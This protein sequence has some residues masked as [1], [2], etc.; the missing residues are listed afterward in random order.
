ML[1]VWL[2]SDEWHVEW[3]SAIKFNQYWDYLFVDK[4]YAYFRHKTE[5]TRI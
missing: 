5:N 3:S 1:L 4:M 2:L